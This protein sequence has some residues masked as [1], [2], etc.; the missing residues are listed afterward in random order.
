MFNLNFFLI[1]C[2]VTL[3]MASKIVYGNYDYSKHPWASQK[4]TEENPEF[5][6]YHQENGIWFMIYMNPGDQRGYRTIVRLM[7]DNML[8]TY[9]REY[10]EEEERGLFMT[11]QKLSRAYQKLGMTA[12][13]IIAGNN[14]QVLTEDGN[15]Q[16][17]VEKEPSM[18]HGHVL[19]RGNPNNEYVEGVKLLG[20]KLGEWFDLIKVKIP[21][22]ND[23]DM[24]KV[25]AA[26]REVF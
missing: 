20:P 12:Q 7:S 24:R 19:G 26:L 21:W 16:M 25:A 6:I 3:T 18:L 8:E 9:N 5:V 2:F 4:K 15:I 10:T 17:G 14:S 13:V 22:E 1:I 23:S 11:L